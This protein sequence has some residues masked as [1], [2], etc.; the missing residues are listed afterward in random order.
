MTYVIRHVIDDTYTA[1][2]RVAV[3]TDSSDWSNQTGSINAFRRSENA[4]P[5]EK[6]F[7]IVL[8]EQDADKPNLY[9]MLYGSD[10]P[11]KIHQHAN[12]WDFYTAI[13][14]DHR[15]KSFKPARAA[16]LPSC[17]P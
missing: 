3:D 11:L 15:R 17:S 13:G 14:Y 10:S 6:S 8:F 9:N 12:I 4:K 5:L 1:E 2:H 7:Y 16:S